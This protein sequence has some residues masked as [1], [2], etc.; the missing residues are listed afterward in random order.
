MI[1]AGSRG[2]I[3]V[4]RFIGDAQTGLRRDHADAGNA[5]GEGLHDLRELRLPRRRQGEAQL[6]VIPVA[7]GPRPSE[8]R[9]L[10]PESSG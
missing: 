3:G 2:M 1:M 8:G 9:A 7:D 4:T 10:L 6:V 5:T